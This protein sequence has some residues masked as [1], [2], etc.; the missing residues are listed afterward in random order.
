MLT[1]RFNISKKTREEK[2]ANP[3]FQ[4]EKKLFQN[5][6]FFLQNQKKIKKIKNF[7]F[8]GFAEFL[9]FLK[10]SDFFGIF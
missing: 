6:V 2:E 10:F 1:H 8:F 4:R 7:N 3:K 9:G 5:E